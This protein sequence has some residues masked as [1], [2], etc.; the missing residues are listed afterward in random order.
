M[1]KWNV[2]KRRMSYEKQITHLRF[3]QD[4][5]ELHFTAVICILH[6]NQD[7]LKIMM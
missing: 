2:W 1:L 5:S 3:N 7:P 6:Y 4:K